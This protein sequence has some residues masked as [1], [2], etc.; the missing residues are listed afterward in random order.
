MAGTCTLT[1]CTKVTNDED[2]QCLPLY[3]D[4]VT[5]GTV[6]V[7]KLSKMDAG[8][9]RFLTGKARYCAR[10]ARVI[11]SLAGIVETASLLAL[12]YD[13]NIQNLSYKQKRKLLKRMKDIESQLPETQLV[14][15]TLPGTDNDPDVI[16]KAVVKIQQQN[17][18]QVELHKDLMTWV[19]NK[20]NSEP[21]VEKRKAEHPPEDKYI[22]WHKQL[23]KYV[24]RQAS[25]SA[26]GGPE[27]GCSMEANL[28]EESDHECDISVHQIPDVP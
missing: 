14:N 17:D 22:T 26:G 10:V 19:L 15:V 5:I 1:K 3:L 2:E 27:V 8:L 16:C 11:D 25:S 18:V 4:F 12:G 24:S 13:Q 23:G 20:Y 7:V 6:E 21:L 9:Q 28:N